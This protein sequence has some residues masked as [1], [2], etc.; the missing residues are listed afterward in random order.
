[1]SSTRRRVVTY[2]RFDG[3]NYYQL[4]CGHSTIKLAHADLAPVWV[5]CPTCDSDAWGDKS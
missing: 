2:D 4:D 3:V 5:H 1:M